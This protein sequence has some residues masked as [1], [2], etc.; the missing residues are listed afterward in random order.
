[1]EE[2]PFSKTCSQPGCLSGHC[3]AGARTRSLSAQSVLG[4]SFRV[5]RGREKILL[6]DNVLN[7]FL[8][9][10][11]TEMVKEQL[12]Q[13]CQQTRK[14]WWDFYSYKQKYQSIVLFSIHFGN[15]N[16]QIQ[17]PLSVCS[18]VQERGQIYVTIQEQ[19]VNI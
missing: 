8:G 7:T 15:Q 2:K 18:Q 4:H 17:R 1:M 14:V 10:K 16:I 5:L 9:K 13:S 19:L 12:S 11:K 6:P 3:L